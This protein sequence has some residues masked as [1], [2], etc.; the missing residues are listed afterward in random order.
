MSLQS[1]TGEVAYADWQN[2]DCSYKIFFFVRLRWAV[3]T[4]WWKRWS[5]GVVVHLCIAG[6]VDVFLGPSLPVHTKSTKLCFTG[7]MTLTCIEFLL[8]GPPSFPVVPPDTIHLVPSD[9][10][11]AGAPEYGHLMEGDWQYVCCEG[12]RPGYRSCNQWIHTMPKVRILLISEIS[13]LLFSVFFVSN[14]HCFFS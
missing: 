1:D 14:I 7:A 2:H 10:S 6:P 9:I 11:P 3:L 8:L 5:C 13:I 12:N 4:W